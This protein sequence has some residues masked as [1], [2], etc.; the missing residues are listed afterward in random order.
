MKKTFSNKEIRELMQ[1]L[2]EKYDNELIG[3][4]DIVEQ[5]DNII[6][7][8]KQPYF[9]MRDNEII[10]T[11]KLI[12]KYNF[13]KTA[14]VDMGAVKFIVSG[15]D[16]MRPGIAEMD[17]FAKDQIIAIIDINNKKVLA[18]GKALLSSEEIKAMNKGKSIKNMHFISDE[19]WNFTQ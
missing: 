2:K 12:N 15:A 5:I 19:I 16:I 17:D 6:L 1:K 18:V 4:K 10:P 7:I 14:A 13:L 3:K 11:I 8:N 9:F